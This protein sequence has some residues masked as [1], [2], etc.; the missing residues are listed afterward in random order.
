MDVR[1]R[2]SDGPRLP[3]ETATQGDIIHTR[4][5]LLVPACYDDTR[6]ERVLVLVA[7]LLEDA[8]GGVDGRPFAVHLS[9]P[10][11]S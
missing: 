7:E 11:V 2:T 4:A 3:E 5:D 8:R 6:R 1:K 9:V 10:P